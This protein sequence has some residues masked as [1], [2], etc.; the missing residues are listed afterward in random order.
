MRTYDD[1]TMHRMVAD[2]GFSDITITRATQREPLQLVS[3]RR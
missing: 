1:E 3:A 2:A